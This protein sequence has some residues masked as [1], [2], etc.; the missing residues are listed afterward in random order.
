[1]AALQSSAVQRAARP[2]Y[3][4]KGRP[5]KVLANHFPVQC[6]LKEASHYDVDVKQARRE[7]EGA[8]KSNRPEKAMP[9]ELLRCAAREEAARP[10]L[11]RAH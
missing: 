6:N 1:M 9:T 4:S 5:I 8:G 7:V 3:G 10:F 2:N 11:L